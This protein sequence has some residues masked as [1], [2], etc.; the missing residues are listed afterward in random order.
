MGRWLNLSSLLLVVVSVFLSSCYFNAKI[1]DPE[2]DSELSYSLSTS[3]LS[4]YS[5][6]SVTPTGGGIQF[7]VS[8]ALPA[9]LTL[10]P[11]TG[12]IGGIP[13]TPTLSTTY[14]ITTQS[15]SGV[16]RTA[17]V[18]FEVAGSYIVD[19]TSDGSDN[20]PGNGLCATST[21][22]CTLRAA[23]QEAAAQT[24]GTLANISLS[25]GT[26]LVTGSSL[27]VASRV[28]ITGAGAG[29]TTISGGSA[30]APVVSVTTTAAVTFDSLAVKNGAQSTGTT[31]R[32]V[33][34]NSVSADFTMK[35]CTVSN[36]AVSGGTV[37]LT[38]GVGIYWKSM[39]TSS[40]FRIDNCTIST[41][42]NTASTA[43][44]NSQG[45]GLYVESSGSFQISNSTVNGNTINLPG[46]SA[47]GYGA[48]MY[49]NAPTT[50]TSTTVSSNTLTMA[51]MFSQGSGIFGSTGYAYN[52]T[53]LT[54]S[55]NSISGTAGFCFGA[56]AYIN[57]GAGFTLSS[58]T[59]SGNTGGAIGDGGLS[60]LGGNFTVQDSTITGANNGAGL[61][62]LNNT[63]IN[64]RVKNTTIVGTGTGSELASAGSA[65]VNTLTLEHVTLQHNNASG[66]ALNLA[67][68]SSANSTVVIKNSIIDRSAGSSCS[69]TG[70]A[71]MSSQGYNVARDATCGFLVGTGD[72]TNSATIGLSALA[73]NGGST[74]T[75]AIGTGSSAY[76]LVPTGSCTLTTDQRGSA[77]P[78]AGA[79]D[80]GAYEY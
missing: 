22:S 27:P 30:I 5:S 46:G 13:T 3:I 62:Y 32:G 43:N 79:C 69:A 11:E 68:I 76:N 45:A 37:T 40:V 54:C 21:G 42:S 63:H 7:S 49:L 31:A 61:L 58:S 56:C 26:Y 18:T 33:G 71:V 50:L 75:M 60:I 55:S 15:R 28:N 77:R 64:G 19:T 73:S 67:N 6:V 20:A 48:G 14:T 80:A 41:N 29:L 72:V 2:S 9:G 74:Q 1:T 10:N 36:N 66:T 70:S 8:P 34:V 4:I 78:K 39:T 53:G 52:L 25:T 57:S 59:I 12:V 44:S 47:Q 16:V 51:T 38:Q 35:N 24:S 65:T 17:T 23:L